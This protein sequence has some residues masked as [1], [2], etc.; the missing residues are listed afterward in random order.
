[1]VKI[2][3]SSIIHVIQL[4]SLVK[5]KNKQFFTII[6]YLEFGCQKS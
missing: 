3:Y 5:E 1:M 2:L 4:Y 6:A